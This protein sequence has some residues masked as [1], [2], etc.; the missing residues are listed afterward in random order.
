MSPSDCRGQRWPNAV[1]R[2]PGPS[3]TGCGPRP[4][5]SAP[6]SDGCVWI[7]FVRKSFPWPREAGR[8]GRFRS[9][10]KNGFPFGKDGPGHLLI[11]PGFSRSGDP[12]KKGGCKCH[13]LPCPVPSLVDLPLIGGEGGR[14][15]GP[16]LSFSAEFAWNS[17]QN[18][19]ESFF[20]EAK[21]GAG[22]I[23]PGSQAECGNTRL[24]TG[25][26]NEEMTEGRGLRPGFLSETELPPCRRKVPLPRRFLWSGVFPEGSEPG[27]RPPESL[28]PRE[29]GTSTNREIQGAQEGGRS[30]SGQTV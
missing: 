10:G 21:E 11:K 25:E 17:F 7:G 9:Q 12:L 3:P 19:A 20:G 15:A 13:L 30:A 22:Q 29:A 2:Q 26:G 16:G 14:S 8:R 24:R 6:P 27:S 4:T 28:I 1:R 18:L 5:L 23:A